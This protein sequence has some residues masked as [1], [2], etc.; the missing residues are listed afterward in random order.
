MGT[1]NGRVRVSR[2]NN[3]SLV[4]SQKGLTGYYFKYVDTPFCLRTD[5]LSIALSPPARKHF[6][7]LLYVWCTVSTFFK[8]Y[9][10]VLH[11]YVS[12][13]LCSL[14]DDCQ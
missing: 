7:L 12:N 14:K 5:E 13:R 8:V 6:R 1:G 9:Q 11:D 3:S 2:G 4:W 10:G